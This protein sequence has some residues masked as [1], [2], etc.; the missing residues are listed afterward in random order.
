MYSAQRTVRVT[1]KSVDYDWSWT[2]GCDARCFLPRHDFYREYSQVGDVRIR[3]LYIG[4]G[5][6]FIPNSLFQ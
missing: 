4:T 6:A 3:S 1:D 5:P 2:P